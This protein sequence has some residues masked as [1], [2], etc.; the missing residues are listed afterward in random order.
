MALSRTREIFLQGEFMS[1]LR[2]LVLALGSN[3]DGVSMPYVTYSHAAAL[4]E[5]HDVA[6]V[7]GSPTEDPVRRAKAPFRA[8]EVVR[9]PFLEAS[10]LRR[11]AFRLGMLPLGC[12]PVRGEAARCSLPN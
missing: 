2:V 11:F 9:M 5:L 6:L 7:I 1:R 10:Q 12:S 8:I 3:R 4:A